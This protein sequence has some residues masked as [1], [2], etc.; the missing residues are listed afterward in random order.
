MVAD[1]R[2]ARARLR[3][4]AIEIVAEDGARALTARGVADRAGLSAGL[5]RHHFGSMADLLVACDEF[6]AATIR[7]LKEQSIQG[8]PAFDA[9]AAL[10]QSGSAHLMGFLALRLADDSPHIN[11]LV[12]TL[13]EDAADY[14]AEGVE[15]GMLTPTPDER[16]RAAMMTVYALGSLVMYR[17]L[18]RLLD[19]DLRAADLATQPGFAEYLRLQIEVFSGL[20]TPSVLTQYAAAIQQLQE[21][22]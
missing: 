2:T 4:A 7:E 1:D 3:D 5:I 12:D 9:L 18:Q 8:G 10:R 22:S 19:V 11:D 20:I 15:Q 13:A 16:N 6:V 21:E 14:M 17:H